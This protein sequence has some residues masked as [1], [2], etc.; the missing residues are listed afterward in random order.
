MRN[1]RRGIQGVAGVF[2][3]GLATLVAAPSAQG[4][5]AAPSAITV[6]CGVADGVSSTQVTGRVGDTFTIQNT[7]GTTGCDVVSLAEVVTVTNLDGANVLAA[8]TTATVT[9]VGPGFFTVTPKV[10]G[11]TVGTMTVVIGDPTPVPEYE[12]TFDAN[13]GSCSSN[14]LT[15]TAAAGDWYALPTDGTGAFQCHRPGYQLIGWIRNDTLVFG[16]SAQQVPDVHHGQQAAAADHT[17]LH[18][19]WRPIGIELTLDANVSAQHLCIVGLDTNLDVADRKITSLIPEEQVPGYRLPSTAPCTPPGHTFKGWSLS[20]TSGSD[21]FSMLSGDLVGLFAITLYAQWQG[22]DCS[23]P[24]GPGVNWYGCNKG[25][26]DW[27]NQDLRGALLAEGNFMGASFQATNLIGADLRGAMFLGTNFSDAK[28]SDAVASHTDMQ[29]ADLRGA[30][31][32]GADFSNA[33]L[34]LSCMENTTFGGA[35]LAGADIALAVMTLELADY[36]GQPVGQP[37]V[38]RKNQDGNS[39]PSYATAC[40]PNGKP[41]PYIPLPRGSTT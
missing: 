16:G 41:V 28:L 21:S 40:G 39:Y 13:G 5:V 6:D 32:S 8:D 1:M 10:S 35:D 25:G 23:A 17:Y 26:V 19:V 37:L 30:D 15:I 29:S 38:L 3:L 27:S 20:G 9:I 4:A 11:P 14:P 2:V 31:L 12:I 33:N 24:P 18:A 22:P 7:S 34:R 36:T